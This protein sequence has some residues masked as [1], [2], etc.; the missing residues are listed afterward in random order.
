MSITLSQEK[1]IYQERRAEDQE[2][3]MVGLILF[4]EFMNVF[5]RPIFELV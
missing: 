2:T 1:N 4:D 5:G 3:V